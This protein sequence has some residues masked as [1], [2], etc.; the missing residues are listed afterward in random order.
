MSRSRTGRDLRAPRPLPGPA[1]V[2]GLAG[3]AAV[4]AGC[5]F[6]LEGHTPLPKP[7]SVSYVEAKDPQSD[8]VQGLRK[9]LRAAGARVTEQS[10]QATA[11][12]HVLEDTATPRV[13]S[14]S[15]AD[16]PIEYEITYTVRVSVTADGKDLLAPQ[17]ITARRDYTFDQYV[18][19]AK[20]NEGAI[21]RA[22]LA[23]DLVDITMRRL[24]R[25]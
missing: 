21:L 13:L 16:L 19:L 25:L 22:A 14:V 11:V 17:E 10:S 15:T 24:T 1:L 9:A 4:L 20:D 6:R 8:F 7:L 12:V 2:L 18:M 23:H 3:L 5:G